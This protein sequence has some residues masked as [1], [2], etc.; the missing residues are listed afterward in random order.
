MEIYT[1]N[2]EIASLG[3]T[4]LFSKAV[5][6]SDTIWRHSWSDLTT[7]TTPMDNKQPTKNNSA[8]EDTNPLGA[9][10]S[11]AQTVQVSDTNINNSGIPG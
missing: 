7:C 8:E 11:D 5:V 2:Y 3:E 9:Q 4:L 1:G 6:A 10:P